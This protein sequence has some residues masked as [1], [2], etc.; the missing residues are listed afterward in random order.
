MKWSEI[1]ELPQTECKQSILTMLQGVGFTATSWQ[2]GSFVLGCVEIGSYIW[3]KFTSVAVALKDAH[4]LQ[5]AEDEALEAYGYSQ[6]DEPITGASPAQYLLELTCEVGEGPHNLDVS[7]VVATDGEFTYRNVAGNSIVYPYALAGG[8]VVTFLFEAEVPGAASTVGAGTITQLQ[9]TYAGVTITDGALQTS[10]L[11]KE[12]AE[13]YRL[14]CRTKWPTLSEG[15]TIY[16]HVVNIC[17]N[18]DPLIKRVTVDDSNPRGDYTF[19]AYVAGE[20]GIVGAGPVAAAQAALDLRF[21]GSATALAVAAAADVLAITGTVYYDP[22]LS[23][24][25]AQV[26]VEAALTAWFKTIP[27]NGFLYGAGL[28]NIVMV[29]DVRAAIR[30]ARHAGEEVVR[31]IVLTAPA[32]DHAVVN[33]DVVTQGALTLTYTA[34]TS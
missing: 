31:T 34:A 17:L 13:A 20:S 33:F 15:E 27:I 16:D 2:P 32:A 26:A 5:T 7:D 30:S 22:N 10:G 21:F 3:S 25:D 6:Y 18:A 29:E 28:N 1:V 12:T 4:L 23:A 24:S 9:T 19:D 8:S 11:D 14:R